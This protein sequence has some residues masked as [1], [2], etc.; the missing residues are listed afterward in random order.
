[1]DDAQGY[2]EGDDHDLVL[3]KQ[4]WIKTQDM[5]KSK[6]ILEDEF[7]WSLPSVG[8]GL[9]EPEWCKL[10]YIGGTDISFLKEDPSTACAAVVVL[11]VDTLEVVHEEFNVV[12]LQVPYIPGFLA[13]RE[14]PV[15]LGLLEKVKIN[16]PHFCPQLLMVDGNGLLH[17]RGF[18]LACHLG[19]L[20]DIPTVGV[21]KNL[22]HVDGLNQSEV[23]RL[24]GSKENCNRELVLLTGQSGTKWGMVRDSTP[25]LNDFA[26]TAIVK[27]CCRYRVPEPTRQVQPTIM[28]G[29]LLNAGRSN[30]RGG[31]RT[32]IQSPPQVLSSVPLLVY[33]Y[34]DPA[35][36]H[37]AGSTPTAAA[38]MLMY[39]LP[40]RSIVYTHD[41]RPQAMEGNF[42]STPQGWLVILGQVTSEASMW[43]PLTGETITLPPIH[44]DH[45]IPTNC[46][47]LLT[48]N[49]AAHPD[50]AV[51]L[52]DV[53]D[54]L[55]WFCRV[56]GGAD[57]RWGQHTYDIGDYEFL[58]EFRT[59]STPT[60]KVI[61]SVAA[62]KGKLHF[63]FMESHQNKMCV[64]DLDFPSDHGHPPTAEFHEFDVSPEF[65]IKFPDGICSIHLVE[66]M[67]ELFAVCVFY[68]GFDPTNV[69][70]ARIFK[71][72]DSC[73][74][75][76]VA[77]H[78]VDDIGDRA[79]LLTGTN[80]ATWC[81]ASTNN[82]KG[83]TLYF[84]LDFLLG[85]RDLYIYDVQ[86]QSMETVQVHDQL[87]SKVVHTEPYWINVPPF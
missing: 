44:D 53:A 25:D 64:V 45:Y 41:S 22:H 46:K 69:S 59:P 30:G 54:P 75:E 47:C 24:L 13:F 34:E 20:A 49:S 1:M 85:D 6:L 55:M 71:M 39:S 48:H 11:N 60:K 2:Q 83:S 4:E 74:E 66:S 72:E 15:L 61:G 3:Q 57:R 62:L 8:S 10:K 33:E 21:G 68:V 35:V 28:V 19:V 7:A 86:E 9:D 63:C 40:E 82:L 78:R 29:M 12:R 51:V 65:G 81:S 5:L 80:M 76:T 56:N 32:S 37:P 50:C 58:D 52:L 16:A 79:F 77:W 70:A 31:R 84:F 73:G 18:G 23:R 87:E 17:P 42:F 38:K 26:A 36:V 43:H 14:A 67:D 27:S